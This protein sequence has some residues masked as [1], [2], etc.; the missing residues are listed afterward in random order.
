MVFNIFI[1][2]YCGYSTMSQ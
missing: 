1:V 2:E